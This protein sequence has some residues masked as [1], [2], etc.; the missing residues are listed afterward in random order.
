MV[1]S[2]RVG[3]PGAIHAMAA[4]LSESSSTKL[5]KAKSVRSATVLFQTSGL[6]H[7][8]ERQSSVKCGVSMETPQTQFFVS[9]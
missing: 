9:K 8:L 7:F 1:E 2:A 3:P 6:Q 4:Y 5:P